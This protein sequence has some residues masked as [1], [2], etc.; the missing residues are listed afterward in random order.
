MATSTNLEAPPA[1]AAEAGGAGVAA[2]ITEAPVPHPTLARTFAAM[3]AREFR[4]LRRNA[5]ATF[6]RA[7]MQPLLF[8][9]VFAY[10][11]PKIGGGFMLGGAAGGAA[12]AGAAA[13]GVNFATILVPG[14]MASMLLMQGIMAVT[15]PLVMEF[16]WQRTIED[17]ALAPVPIRV[18][19][20]QKISAGAVQSFI[21][22]LIVFPIV[23]LV[24]ASGQAPSVHVTN[25]ALFALILVAASMLTAALGLLLGTIMDPRKMQMLFAVILLPATMLGCVY[26]PWSAL[27]SI[28][29]L[30]ILVL[31][32]PMVYMSEGLRA[33]LTPELGHMPLWAVLLVLIGGS[34]VFGYLGARTFRNRVLN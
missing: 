13:S 1:G 11:F 3:M 34:V 14:L 24:H 25:W 19:A 18:L 28:R 9:F 17:R 12:R 32:N 30:Q 15:F 22:A 29:W 7:V 27:H 5:V 26:Y 20:V 8:V 16:S 6:T 10:V 31:V 33:V 23:L 4:V 21:G 2:L